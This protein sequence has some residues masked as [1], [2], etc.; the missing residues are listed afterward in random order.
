M[1]VMGLRLFVKRL[2]VINCLP[3]PR[4]TLRQAARKESTK[5]HGRMTKNPR[6]DGKN[7]SRSP[8]K[9]M[10]LYTIANKVARTI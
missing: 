1:D 2:L 6:P 4:Q 9:I 8:P 7:K 3:V 5:M 10:K